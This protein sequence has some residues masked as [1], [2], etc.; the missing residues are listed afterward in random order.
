MST[1]TQAPQPCILA[2]D[3]DPSNL[4]L[5]KQILQTH[6]R[7]LFARDGLRAIELAVQERPDLILLDVMMPGMTGFEVCRHL[8]ANPATTSIPVI[9]VTALTDTS[10][11]VV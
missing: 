11:E 10:D 6:Y 1:T 2:V 3:D 5:L 4:H 8:K 9:F 7:M